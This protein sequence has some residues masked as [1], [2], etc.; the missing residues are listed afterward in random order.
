MLADDIRV[1]NT[2]TFTYTLKTN[3]DSNERTGKV[4]EVGRSY[5]RIK[6]TIAP[7]IVHYPCFQKSAMT[8]IKVLS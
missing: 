3:S 7:N 4:T 1:D 6:E 8:N 2:I 5:V